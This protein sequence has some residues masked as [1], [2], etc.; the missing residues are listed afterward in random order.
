MTVQLK[1]VAI[2][3]PWLDPGL[4]QNH[5]WTLP[6]SGDLTRVSTG[7]PEDPDP[8]ALPVLVTGV[9]L[10]KDLFVSGRWAGP[11]D[12]ELAPDALGPFAL[13]TP[14]GARGLPL[15]PYIT[16][17]GGELSIRLEGVQIIGFFCEPVPRSPSPDPRYFLPR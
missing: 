17:G 6:A 4:F 14:Q 3:R 1:R 2:T 11:A 9:L 7:H 13:A 15:H 5:A 16:T 10:A 12:A 8:G